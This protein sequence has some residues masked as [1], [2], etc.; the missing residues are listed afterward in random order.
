MLGALAGQSPKATS[1]AVLMT[2]ET[3]RA[4]RWPAQL[5]ESL[6]SQLLPDHHAAYQD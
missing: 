2:F 1:L 5:L 4:G 6:L 3:L